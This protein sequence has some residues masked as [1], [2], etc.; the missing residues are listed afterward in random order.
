MK[1]IKAVA[2]LSQSGPL[3][4]VRGNSLFAMQFDFIASKTYNEE[5]SIIFGQKHFAFALEFR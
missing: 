1:R 4:Y 5:T 2:F 3:L